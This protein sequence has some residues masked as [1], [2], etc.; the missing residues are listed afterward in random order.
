MIVVE[1]YG[2]STSPRSLRCA[3]FSRS[4]DEKYIAEIQEMRLSVG[5]VVLVRDPIRSSLVRIKFQ[6]STA[7]PELERYRYLA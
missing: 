6:C 2:A 1:L 4:L 7:V 5:C 3:L